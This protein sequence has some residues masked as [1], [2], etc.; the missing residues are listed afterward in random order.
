MSEV[1]KGILMLRKDATKP[2]TITK[3]GQAFTFKKLTMDAE[4]Q[5][6]VIIQA[7]QDTSL[8]PPTQ[9]EEGC[10]EDVIDQYIKDLDDHSEKTQKLFRRLTCDL[11]K[12]MLVDDNG[13][14]MFDEKDDIYPI[15]NNVF[16]QN[17]FNAYMEFRGGNSGG[18]AE[19]ESRFQK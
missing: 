16:A 9:P 15:V 6:K 1:S 17:F 14:D 4:D 3:G 13:K 11:M 5:I 2:V 7:H 10:S 8:K 18:V 12:F 19:A